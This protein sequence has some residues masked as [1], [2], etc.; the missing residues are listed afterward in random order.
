MNWYI[1]GVSLELLYDAILCS[2]TKRSR[3]LGLKEEAPSAFLFRPV[4]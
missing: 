3:K 1:L 4:G 2:S